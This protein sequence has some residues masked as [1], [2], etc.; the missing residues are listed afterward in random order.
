MLS[1]LPHSDVQR[2]DELAIQGVA[3][4]GPIHGYDADA[5]LDF[6]QHDRNFPC[7]STAVPHGASSVAET[8]TRFPNQMF[9]PASRQY[10]SRICRL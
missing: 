3:A 7:E 10:S 9:F 6:R 5:V 1:H 8:S 4:T 2:L